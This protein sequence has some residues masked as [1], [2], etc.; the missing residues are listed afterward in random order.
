[1]TLEDGHYESAKPAGISN[2][3]TFTAP[4]SFV[5]N[6]ESGGDLLDYGIRSQDGC[7]MQDQIELLV[8]KMSQQMHSLQEGYALHY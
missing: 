2:I 8:S 5:K 3:S 7:S 4:D 1:M 6:W